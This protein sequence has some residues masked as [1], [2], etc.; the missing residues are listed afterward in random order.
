MDSE[1]PDRP[2]ADPQP[3]AALHA[4]MAAA[5]LSKSEVA[6]RTGIDQ[7]TIQRWLDGQRVPQSRNARTL[8]DLLG[9]EPAD[10]WPSS[11]PVMDPPSIGTVPV[12]VYGSRAHVPVAVWH[13]HFTAAQH[14]IDIL[15]YG[16]TFLFDTVPGFS[17]LIEQAAERGVTVRFLTGDSD[18]SAVHKRGA[19]EGIGEGL[20]GRCR[21]TLT[22]L[23]PLLGVEGV[24][25][26]THG[27]T[28]YVSMFR[29]DEVL[30]ANHH[31]HGSPASDNPLLLITREA[32]PQLWNKY[33]ASFE[34]IWTRARPHHRHDDYREGTS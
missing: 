24:E 34:D 12:S 10:I 20:P 13:N 16:G 6:S 14:S 19:E 9:C 26:R 33:L 22:R 23:T 30:I 28:L 2:L 8:A 7:R 5:G 11:Y 1:Q 31:I 4:R 29:A 25:V 17:H 32:D 15:V 18:A 27:T 21:L 3:N